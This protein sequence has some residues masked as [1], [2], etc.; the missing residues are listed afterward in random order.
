[1]NVDVTGIFY[2]LPFSLQKRQNWDF[3]NHYSILTD[4][5][6]NNTFYSILEN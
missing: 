3:Y 1:M 6:Q 4:K 2:E 5:T